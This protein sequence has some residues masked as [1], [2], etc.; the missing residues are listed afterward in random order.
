MGCGQMGGAA[1]HPAESCSC[2]AGKRWRCEGEAESCK[3]CARC[4]A[5]ILAQI[6]PVLMSADIRATLLREI[7]LINCC[8]QKHANLLLAE[9]W[10]TRRPSE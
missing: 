5:P 8:F 4:G 3:P 6:R 1:K 2:S 7:S 9:L 10:L